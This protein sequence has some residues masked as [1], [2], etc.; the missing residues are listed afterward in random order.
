MQA[1]STI[2]T[3]P[4]IISPLQINSDLGP[5]AKGA[6]YFDNAIPVS[7][8]SNALAS[9]GLSQNNSSFR[10]EFKWRGQLALSASTS[11]SFTRH[12]L[13]SARILGQVD[14]KFI[15]CLIGPPQNI[16]LDSQISTSGNDPNLEASKNQDEVL[17]LV[18]QHAAD[19][20][21]RVE[22]LLKELCE[23]F[24][25]DCVDRCPARPH[26]SFDDTSALSGTK[27]LLSTP[28]ADA[29]TGGNS[30]Y[31]RRAFERWGFSFGTLEQ[32]NHGHFTQIEA[33]TVPSILAEKV[34]IYDF[35]IS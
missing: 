35:S 21:V 27:I 9:S 14:C 34:R 16:P 32:T 25:Q 26:S 7:T 17:V 3:I 28:E 18:D 23:T 30:G 31:V 10:Q 33:L 2:P 1:E 22:R 12:D 13:A 29:L 8:D 20:R 4:L 6:A 15:A 5:R 24:I 11:R 19:E